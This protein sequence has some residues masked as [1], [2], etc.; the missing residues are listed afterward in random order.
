MKYFMLLVRHLG[1]GIALILIAAAILLF[2]DPKRHRAPTQTQATRRPK[3]A[4]VNY[5]SINVLEEGEAGF[6]AGLAADGYVD[7]QNVVLKKFNAEGDR[8]TAILIAKE[9]VG[10]DYDLITTISTPTLQAVAGANR[11]TKRPHLF[12]LCTDPWAA[13]VGLSHDKDVPQP[14]YMTGYGTMQPVTALFKLARIANPH[15]KKVGVAWNPAESNSEAS[16]KAAR[17]ICQELGIELVEVTVDSSSAV[18]DAARALVSR[19]VEAIWAGGDTTVS[20]GMDGI[21]ATAREAHLPVFTNMPGDVK[22]GVM[23]ALG[24]DYFEVG[25]TSGQLAAQLLK[26]KSPSDFPVKNYVPEK[27][28]LNEVVWEGT[29]GWTMPAEWKQRAKLRIDASGVHEAAR[30]TPKA[31]VSQPA[32]NRTYRVSIAY[33]APNAASE[34]AIAGLQQKLGEL[35]FVKGKNVEYQVEHAQ[36]DMALIP[37]LMQKLDQ[38]DT[39]L[40]VSLTTPCLTAACTMVKSKPVVFTEV[41][42]PLAAGAGTSATEHVPHVTG[43]GSFPPIEKMFDTMQRIIPNLKT[44]GVVYNSGEANS[45]KA[46]DVARKLAAE[47]GLTLEESTVTNSSEI[48]QAAQVLA[49]K[50]VDVL[51]ELGDNTVTQGLEAL[52]KAGLDARI[53]V[54]NSDAEAAARGS[55]VG[56]GIRFFDS[57]YAAGELAARVLLGESPSNLPFEEV[58]QVSIAANL[59]TAKKLDREFQPDFLRDCSMFH[60]ARSRLDRPL[61]VAFVELVE[62]PS[63][64]AAAAGVQTGLKEA[65]LVLD[66]DITF[67]KYNAQGDLTQLPQIFQTI[68]GTSPDLIITSTTPAMIAAA[69]ATKTTPIVFTV[70]SN[71]PDVGVYPVGEQQPNLVG[72]YDDPPIADLLKLAERR[73]GSIKTVGTIWNPAEPNSEISVKRLRAACKEQGIQL[74]ERHAAAANELRDVTSAICLTG[75][76]ILVV[77]AD[78]VTSSGFPAIISVTQSQKIPVY[79]TEPD[80]VKKGAA[81][82]I[83]IDYSDWGKQSAALAAQILAG[84]PVETISSEKVRSV[85]PVTAD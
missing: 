27:L 15:L 48:L 52:I 24:A 22:K 72:V 37:A 7:G 80:L 66:Q 13:G 70:A 1:V 81:A 59:D 84:V 54:V 53:P 32:P 63:L 30:E 17:A 62:G 49:Q 45:R 83:G 74:V 44:V 9:V 67:Q 65:G 18:L 35:G 38:S 21:V 55:L 46:I 16:T 31:A 60:G 2:T 69:R 61:R 8:P 85:R 50:N 79:C 82:A 78:N 19:G 71:P 40:I 64:E 10:Q 14:A 41:Y 28:G 42:D 25:F 76:D 5:T 68:D 6:I 75:I 33:F 39:D 4:I 29:P 58:A 26:G 23:F 3:V 56:V 51:W 20:A 73:E 12:T 34:S 57:G 47:K 77:S 36:G 11:E 43:V